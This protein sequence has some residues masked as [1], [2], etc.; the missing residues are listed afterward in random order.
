MTRPRL[1]MES[2]RGDGTRRRRGGG[3]ALAAVSVALVVGCNLVGGVDDD[4]VSRGAGWDGP[5]L[6]VSSPG[7][8]NR[9]PGSWDDG[10]L[11]LGNA[12]TW[13]GSADCQCAIPTDACSVAV[14]IVDLPPAVGCMQVGLSQTISPNQ[15]V[16]LFAG[17][18]YVKAKLTDDPRLCV[19]DT[20]LPAPVF[21][22]NHR[23]C[24][25]NGDCTTGGSTELR[26]C[27]RQAGL[28][29]CDELGVEYSE[30][31]I[32]YGGARDERNCDCG[33]VQCDGVLE[34]HLPQAGQAAGERCIN[35]AAPTSTSLLE[36][37]HD[38]LPNEE[39]IVFRF[40]D[41]S[42]SCTRSGPRRSHRTGL[43]DH[44]RDSLLRPVIKPY[45]PTTSPRGT[46]ECSATS[47][48]SLPGL[49]AARSYCG[50]QLSGR[51]TMPS[52]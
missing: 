50:D 52:L 4:F 7:E 11:Y 23:L 39:D 43:H 28:N 37:C 24:D 13:A 30:R 14:H 48:L 44:P 6:V 46:V 35:G 41:S 27:L 2:P 45:G 49:R 16:P 33:L 22:M 40:D 10:T 17:G 1:P 3:I 26:R 29:N 15:C 19:S 5:F 25:C 12:E 31:L 21:E 18:N 38:Q 8:P 36:E 51:P 42:S 47:R 20:E 34:I 32:V 9:C